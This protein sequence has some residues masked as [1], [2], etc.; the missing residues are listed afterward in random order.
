MRG[1]WPAWLWGA[2]FGEKSKETRATLAVR[3][4][5][6]RKRCVDFGRHGCGGRNSGRRVRKHGRLCQSGKTA[7]EKDAWILDG[8]VVGRNSGR[9]VREHSR[10]RQSGTFGFDGAKVADRSKSVLLDAF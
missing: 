5:G 10:L 8:M 9:R 6:K 3:E 4:N 1:F 7:N 2:K